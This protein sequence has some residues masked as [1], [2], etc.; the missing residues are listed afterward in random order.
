MIVAVLLMAYYYYE[1]DVSVSPM[2]K[3]LLSSKLDETAS[4]EERKMTDML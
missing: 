4:D 1:V 2:M 3:I